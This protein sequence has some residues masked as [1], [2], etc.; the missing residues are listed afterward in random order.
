MGTGAGAMR[1]K[2]DE[3]RKRQDETT[4]RAEELVNSA[5]QRHEATVTN[6][7]GENATLKERI[8]DLQWALRQQTE[9]WQQEKAKNVSM[10]FGKFR[11]FSVASCDLREAHSVP[12]TA[13]G[14]QERLHDLL[15]LG[16][17]QD[18]RPVA[19]LECLHGRF[20]CMF[21]RVYYSLISVCSANFPLMIHRHRHLAGRVYTKFHL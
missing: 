9:L 18:P 8:Q 6:V 19:S 11:T 15:Q 10:T 16:L 7:T 12:I 20:A 14:S 3:E 13:V 4:R 17:R 1:R 5:E 21:S 2:L